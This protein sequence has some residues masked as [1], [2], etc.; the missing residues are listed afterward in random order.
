MNRTPILAFA[1]A[2]ALSSHTVLLAQT[3][4]TRESSQSDNLM[5]RLKNVKHV[6]VR[7]DERLSGYILYLYTSAQ[8]EQNVASLAAYRENSEVFAA[9]IKSIDEKR[10]AAQQERA[11]VA[12]LNAMTQERN[13]LQSERPTSQ[14]VGSI[15]LYDV[16]KFGVDYVELRGAEKGGDP[17]LIPLSKICKVIVKTSDDDP[18]T[19]EPSDEPRSR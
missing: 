9:R 14:F 12:D 3:D 2:A 4:S 11:S 5:L 7:T 6:G 16:V 10:Q 15:Y 18:K 17:V 8:R 19:G 1:L 13:R